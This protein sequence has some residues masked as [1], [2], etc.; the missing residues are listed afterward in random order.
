MSEN[1]E[2]FE[3]V[4]K[5]RRRSMWHK[6]VRVMACIVVFC[7]TYALILPAITQE[8]VTYCGYEEHTHNEICYAAQETGSAERLLCVL[9]ET[10]GHTHGEDC[11]LSAHIHGDGCYDLDDSLRICGQE[12]CQPHI[13]EENCYALGEAPLICTEMQCEPHSH[14]DGCYTMGEAPLICTQA[15]VQPHT[16]ID[17]CYGE[18]PQICVCGQEESEN[19]THGDDCYCI[20]E[21]PL[22]CTLA[23]TEGH[24][25]GTDCYG[26]AQLQ[27]TCTLEETAGHTHGEFCFGEA[28]EVLSCTL[29]ETA[30]HTHSE[31]CYSSLEKILVCTL[32][33]REIDELICTLEEI[34]AHAHDETCYETAA[35]ELLCELEEHTHELSCFADPSADLETASVWEK[36]LPSELTGV[37]AED[38]LEVAKSQ[39]GY[40]ESE[41]NYQVLN[42]TIL[43]G[44]S[45]YGH[46][47]GDPYGDW[48][49]YFVRF[50]LHYAEVPGAD[51]PSHNDASKWIE[52]LN[53]AGLYASEAGFVPMAGDVIFLEYEGSTLTG[54]VTKANEEF[55]TA[56]MGDY[57]N[58]VRSETIQ[59]T[60]SDILGYGMMPYQ[61][62]PETS[63]TVEETTMEAENLGETTENSD[64]TDMVPLQASMTFEAASVELQEAR[65]VTLFSKTSGY[66]DLS[67]AG[68]NDMTGMIKDVTVWHKTAAWGDTWKELKEGE[69]VNA[70]DLIRFAIQYQ[71]PGETLSNENNSIY[72]QLPVT[73]ISETKSGNV[74]DNNGVKVGIYSISPS[75]LI[76]ITFDDHYVQENAGGVVIDGTINFDSSVEE[77]KKENEDKIS[78]EFKDGETVVVE[79]E[80]TITND[81]TVEKASSVVDE[82][83][84]II[85]YTI[86]V[87]S[88]SGTNGEVSLSDWMGNV[89]YLSGLKVTKTTATGESAN[90]DLS[91]PTIGATSFEL[92]LPQMA[93]GDTYTITYQGKVVNASGGTVSANNGVTVTSKNQENNTLTD[94][95]SSSVT[96]SYVMVEK[97]YVKNQDGTITWTVTVGREGLSLTG[98]TL[99][100]TLNGAALTGNVSISGGNL[101]S[102]IVTTLP[103]T[104]EKIT[105]DENEQIDVTGP[106]TVTYTT[107]YEYVIGGGNMSNTATLTP[108]ADA[109]KPTYSDTENVTDN[110]GNFYPL[111]KNATNI[112]IVQD[113]AVVNWTYTINA[114]KGSIY[115]EANNSGNASWYFNDNL[116]NNQYYTEEQWNALVT[117]IQ[118]AMLAA[119]NAQDGR[120]TWST[121]NVTQL[122]TLTPTEN[123][124]K[125]TGFTVTVYQT[126]K[127]GSK[128]EFGYQS[129]ADITDATAFYHF[130]NGAS[131]N[132]KTWDSGAIDYYPAVMKMD[133]TNNSTADTNHPQMELKDNKVSWKIQMFL[134][135]V[136]T[137]VVITE[138]I[139]ELV[140]LS[141]LTLTLPN[142]TS[143]Q[144]ALPTEKESTTSATF[145]SVE[146]SVTVKDISVGAAEGVAADKK[147][148]IIIPAGLA[149]AV[150]YQK[151]ILVVDTTLAN[152]FTTMEKDKNKLQ[153]Q[154]LGNTV[155]VTTGGEGTSTELGSDTHTQTITNEDTTKQIVKAH[156]TVQDNLI[157][158]SITVNPN[159]IDLNQEGDT[160]T[161]Y[162]KLS[163]YNEAGKDLFGANVVPG[164]VKVTR[165]NAD[166]T[167]TELAQGT[168][169][170]DFD[171]TFLQTNTAGENT[172][173]YQVVNDLTFTVPDNTHLI[174]EYTYKISG[175]PGQGTTIQNTASLHEV[176]QEG[177]SSDNLWF[178]VQDSDATANLGSVNVHKVASTNYN[179]DL[180]GATF[181]LYKYDADSREWH[182]DQNTT[183]TGDGGLELKDLTINQA[184]YLIETKAP[185]GYVLD[186]TRKYFLIYDAQQAVDEGGN[187][188][189]IAPE[190]FSAGY[191]VGRGGNVYITNQP[192]GTSV[193][194]KKVWTDAEG[195]VLDT[196]PKGKDTSGNE[197]DAQ[198][199]VQ[200]MQVWSRYPHDFDMSTIGHSAVNVQVIFGGY[201]WQGD[202]FSQTIADA[203]IGDILTITLTRPTNEN[204]ALPGLMEVTA[205]ENIHVPYTVNGNTYT[206]Q[207]LI[208]GSNVT[209]HGWV[210]PENVTGA[211]VTVSKETPEAGSGIT[212]TAY[213]SAITL[214]EVAGWNAEFSNLPQYQ[215]DSDGQIHGYYSYYVKEISSNVDGYIATFDRG[216]SQE[217]AVENGTITVTNKAIPTTSINVQKKWKDNAGQI[218]ETPGVDS[219]TFDLIQVASTTKVEYATVSFEI[220]EYYYNQNPINIPDRVV[221]VGSKCYL[222]IRTPGSDLKFYQSGVEEP[223]VQ[224]G[225]RTLVDGIT[226]NWG[227][228][229]YEY[230]YELTVNQN[231]TIQGAFQTGSDTYQYCAV[232]FA[233]EAELNTTEKPGATIASS[234]MLSAA[235]NWSWSKDE[236]P[237]E[238][239]DTNGNVVYYSYYVKETSVPEG[240]SVTYKT[241]PIPESSLCPDVTSGTLTIVNTPTTDET[242]IQITVEKQWQNADGT[243]YTGILPEKIEFN[244]VKEN[245]GSGSDSESGNLVALYHNAENA[246]SPITA[247]YPDN[248]VMTITVVANEQNCYVYDRLNNWC[249]VAMTTQSSEIT[250]EN[251]SKEYQ[252][253]MSYTVHGNAELNIGNSNQILKSIEVA[254]SYP[255]LDGDTAESTATLGTTIGTYFLNA[256]NNWEMTISN[257]DPGSY[258]VEEVTT[259]YAVLYSVDGGTPVSTVPTGLDGGETVTIINRTDTV[260]TSVSVNKI[261]KDISGNEETDVAHEAVTVKVYRKVE[262]V[263]DESF[264]QT[265]IL[266]EE[267]WSGEL[268]WLPV[269]DPN[270]KG[271]TYYVEE[272]TVPGYDG[273][274]TVNETADGSFSFTITNTAQPVYELPETG[275][276]G[277]TPYTLGGLA[278]L[279]CGAVLFLLKRRQM[280]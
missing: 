53:D 194:V 181:E 16:H 36:T 41:K 73:T 188:T 125:K 121:E 174:I 230:A 43:K 103:Y 38:L 162:D 19:H 154:V 144:L 4:R 75:G 185:N 74:Y 199:Q 66:A 167:R 216:G 246:A 217:D 94:S 254:A 64:L 266:S 160:L 114:D 101:S 161:V 177:S 104:F 18:A 109:D 117:A 47:A 157:P 77:L 205:T 147:Y 268:K 11:Y 108:P 265:L 35:P 62:L 95:A 63:E 30:G 226:T 37:W 134:P 55:I 240:Y 131:I 148:E 198:I 44:Y 220:G 244:L 186:Q 126:L 279:L 50:C 107:P 201:S 45:R 122:Y 51:F 214:S 65:K 156:G 3:Y 27:F 153:T 90:V 227:T 81:L 34:P 46:W 89:G 29:Q 273:V 70:N 80:N 127:K 179:I 99:S 276:I 172:S 72:Y 209:L 247:H 235:N 164:S 128:I 133:G 219:V 255:K 86:T 78:L 40:T 140:N 145:N 150:T 272:V 83:K 6:F 142:G 5:N 277:T 17:A 183:S 187:S 57:E 257:L 263:T 178:V 149:N 251:G 155:K 221:Q 60:D 151:L 136:T 124:G 232:T 68:S 207:Y 118:D 98:W 208:K 202:V 180:A 261:W 59:L 233:T 253:I 105:T 245:T 241:E 258:S 278:M 32:E 132:N 225:E 10:D 130:Q 137:D 139:P 243:E 71:V 236:L 211:S 106:V 13:H 143:V 25:H 42:D 8:Q 196:V 184:Y 87:S 146:Y 54:I 218:T 228:P 274:V 212:E 165:V 242:K 176:S 100:D 249:T 158:Y 260:T 24:V 239:V 26:E 169:A 2:F 115:A 200:L 237:L 175:T 141:G 111:D 79:I 67:R 238:G 215:L 14:G 171:Y 12:E 129:T 163:F 15:E 166:G 222:K 248:T 88:V 82:E 52:K 152:P 84:G 234:Q 49:T 275:G 271:Y 58:Q 22:I 264:E 110:N 267:N 7:T 259:G 224:V 76:T 204:S 48:S 269:K 33:E 39:L 112:T 20:G 270:G 21:A 256:D 69:K 203:K 168:A 61:E 229:V 223:L 119:Y 120:D 280:I 182:F 113:K 93:A 91:G 197:T 252:Y 1:M 189:L 28:E 138:D 135:P 56:I 170:G 85:N 191:Y 102:A 195:N 97:T 123:N 173:W 31:L 92:N 96:Y 231:A 213:G 192:A 193:E 23:E 9:E 159:A 190:G 116:Q 210:Y 250:L 262:E 206:F